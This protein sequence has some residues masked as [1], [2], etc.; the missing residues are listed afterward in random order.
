MP[1]GTIAQAV[2]YIEKCS[3]SEG[4]ICYS[5]R[6]GGGPRLAISAAAVATLY[7]AGQYDVPVA[8]R[9]LEYVWRQF[10]DTK[11]WSK[12]GHDF[13]CHLY[14]SQAFYLAGDKYW[15]V[16]F[17]ADARSIALD[18]GQERGIVE[19]RWDRQGLWHRDRIDHLAIALQVFARLPTLARSRIRDQPPPIPTWKV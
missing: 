5:L 3:T 12:G 15:D 19:R 17:P 13:Y 14:A 4:G 6:S 1:R 2:Q 10:Q 11:Q 18:A 16:Y 8:N 7:N 9:C